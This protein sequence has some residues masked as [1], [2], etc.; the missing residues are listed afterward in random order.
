[1][2]PVPGARGCFH[3]HLAAGPV[4]RSSLTMR[5]PFS[6]LR[7]RLNLLILITV[8]PAWGLILYNA[9]EQRRLAI[10]DI[11]QDLMRLAELTAREEEQVLQCTRQVL[12]A[13]SNFLRFRDGDPATDRR[14]LACLLKQSRSYANLGAVRPD[15]ELFYSA[16]AFDGPFNAAR[17]PWFQRAIT[18]RGFAAG[19][20]RIAHAGGA[21]PLVLAHPVVDA[22][23]QVAAVVY[24][25]IDLEGLHRFGGEFEA[26]FPP[27]SV[28][29]QV[30]ESGRVLSRALPPL[31]RGTAPLAGT[32]VLEALNTGGSGV[33]EAVGLDS[34]PRVYAYAP[35]RSPLTERTM[36]VILGVP[37][38]AAFAA[39]NRALVRNLA[40]LAVVAVFASLCTWF[41]SDLF[42]LRQVGA[43]VRASRRLAGGNLSTRIAPPDGFGE[44]N[45]LALAFD[46]M[47]AALE[48]RQRDREAAEDEL[49]RSREQLRD[50]SAH[51]QT[52]RE[53]ERTR[54]ARELHDELGQALTA[55]KM[56]VSWLGKRASS[57]LAADP[58]AVPAKIGSMSDLI[59]ATIGTVHRLTSEL[60]PGI[61]SDLG[62]L[63]A[64]EWQAEEFQGRT[65]IACRV[66]SN[67]ADVD[68][69]R[70]LATIMFRILQEALTN[71]ARHARA[72]AVDVVL[73][74]RDG[75]LVLEV[76]D[77][78]RGITEAEIESSRSFGLIG[79][80]ERVH[81]WGGE[82]DITGTPGQ[83]TRLTVHVPLGKGA[84][85]HG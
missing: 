5:L 64:I 6:S 84:G 55:L 27:N 13:L 82:V 46:N 29:V 74:R 85:A 45:Q 60:R 77:D 70:D 24:A 49:V 75:A 43:L 41:G 42:I 53:E 1:M 65:E 26:L 2:R 10:S 3:N 80:R 71:V 72:A 19:D 8:I 22:R 4:N 33:V 66:T 14:F 51:L 15:G 81:P 30:D 35:L 17:S 56:D 20:D 50:L 37:A 21:K 44:L 28:L 11:Q 48:R 76:L 40:L 36:Y 67:C 68:V 18:T 54:I 32:A 61:L 16:V 12:F 7:T 38:K 57:A 31:Q 34:I 39:S 58:G 25:E 59:D 9:S 52:V 23:D 83:G 62:L 73:E 47:A 79:I 63:A 78:G 69:E